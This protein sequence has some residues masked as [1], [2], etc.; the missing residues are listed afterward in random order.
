MARSTDNKDRWILS[1]DP[2]TGKSKVLVSMHDDAWVGGPGAAT[3]GWMKNDR[4]VYFASEKTGYAQLYAVS[5]EGGSE[6]R[7]LTS[8]SFEVIDAQLSE[9]KSTFYLTTSEVSPYERHLYGMPA[10]GGARKK[11]TST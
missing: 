9:D 1:I 6:P 10:E 4:D 5:S 7:A 3:L 2:A 11:I 8:G